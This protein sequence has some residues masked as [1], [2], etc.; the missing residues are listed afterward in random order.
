MIFRT[1]G[2]ERVWK[3]QGR[4]RLGRDAHALRAC[5]A[6]ALRAFEIGKPNGCLQSN[7]LCVVCENISVQS[8]M[9]HKWLH[10]LE[11]GAGSLRSPLIPNKVIFQNQRLMANIS[12]YNDFPGRLQQARLVSS[13]F[14]GTLAINLPAF[15]ETFLMAKFRPR[16]DQSER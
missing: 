9:V 8:R 5:E 3:R 15:I 6:R 14:Y 1:K 12:R 7:L 13:L 10:A 4:Y 11:L 16:R 2:L